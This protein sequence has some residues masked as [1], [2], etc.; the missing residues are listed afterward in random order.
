MRLP[1]ALLLALAPP[2]PVDAMDAHAEAHAA[3]LDVPG[4]AY[5][6]VGPDG[7]EHAFRT[8]VDGAGDPVDADTAFLWGSVAKPV[9]AT[10]AVVLAE[11][12][13]LDLDA[14]VGDHLPAFAGRDITVRH[15]MTHTSGIPERAAFAVTDRYGEDAMDLDGRVALLADVPTG[16]PGTHE[17]S[18]ANHVLLGAVIEDVTGDPHGHLRESVLEPAGM[19]GAFTDAREARAAGLAP[20]HRF[21]WGRPVADAD[22]VDDEGVTYGYLGGTLDDLAAFARLQLAPEPPLLDADTLAAMREGVVPVPGSTQ[23]YG[24]SW[25]E[26][27]L[28]GTEEPVVFHGG[29]TPGHAAMVV[30]LPERAR[31]VVVLQNAYAVAADGDLQR[32]AFDLARLLVDVPVEEPAA[33]W[34][35]PAVVWGATGTA[36]ALGAAALRPGR[37]RTRSALGVLGVLAVVA[38]VGTLSFLGPRASLLWFP[39]VT[40]AVTAGGV[41]GAVA[42]VR[43]L[44]PLVRRGRVGAP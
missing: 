32:I 39:D 19:A 9:T 41:L 7:V 17:Y 40:V 35:A 14:P 30:V 33:G 29:A 11:E 43:G 27:V 37:G 44:S 10:A 5:A 31:A 25:R 21:L 2:P 23:T 36:L 42:A 34:I 22:G 20:G 1:L 28:S 24:L 26:T 15:L 3:A 16:E 4:L 38:A 12:G 8:G 13:R 6:V 18:S